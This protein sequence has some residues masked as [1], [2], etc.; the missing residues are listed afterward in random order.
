M[1]PRV[2]VAEAA[3]ALIGWMAATAA[4]QLLPE[5]PLHHL[6]ID[7]ELS[8]GVWITIDLG[9]PPQSV[10]VLLGEPT[11]SSGQH[12][13]RFAEQ[14]FLCVVRITVVLQ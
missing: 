7:G 4:G 14:H 6:S 8:S 13:P 12:V 3:A 11:C 2:R 1:R 9:T 10:A 5:V